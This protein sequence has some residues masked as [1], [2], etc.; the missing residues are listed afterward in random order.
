[1]FH[2]KKNKNIN[3]ESANQA[4]G[5]LE[6]WFLFPGPNRAYFKHVWNVYDVLPREQSIVKLG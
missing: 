6:I 5:M 3:F 4:G 1:M 2:R